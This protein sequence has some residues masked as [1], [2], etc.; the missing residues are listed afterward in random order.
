MKALDQCL[1]TGIGLWV[2][3]LVRMRVAP[4]E[5]LE[6]QN[7]GMVRAADDMGPPA[8]TSSCSGSAMAP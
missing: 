6:A 3:T 1:C 2:E 4:K 7:I 5:T 8:P